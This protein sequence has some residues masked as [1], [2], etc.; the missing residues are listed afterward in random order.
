MA[1]GSSWDIRCKRIT[2]KTRRKDAKAQR[3]EGAKADAAGKSA[4]SYGEP[5]MG[6]SIWL[7]CT[8]DP[9]FPSYGSA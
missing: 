9:L 2:R 3:S 5:T 7:V 4:T 8:P 6:R 1:R